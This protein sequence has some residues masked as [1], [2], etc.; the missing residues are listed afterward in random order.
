MSMDREFL[1]ELF[2]P[3]GRV[4]FR[5]MFGGLGIFRDGLMFGLVAGDTLHL[6]ADE[7]THPDFE[8]EGCEPFSYA[9]KTG[10]RTLTSY[11]RMPERLFDEPDEF[12]DWAMRAVETAIR[13][14]A[15][16]A[17]KSARKR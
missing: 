7:R 3:V 11:W 14:D 5:R 12:R 10:K 2:E 15:A 4:A 8:T 6:K 17:S 1:E 13:A 9:T 16:K